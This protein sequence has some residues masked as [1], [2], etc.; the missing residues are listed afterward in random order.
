VRLIYAATSAFAVPSLLA[1]AESG[2]EISAV[3]TQPDRPA[4]RG[5]NTRP[6]PVKEAA[7]A[8]SIAVEQPASLR[9]SESQSR[10]RALAPDF[11]IVAAYGQILPQAVLD[12]PRHGCVNIHAS[13]LPRWRGA[14]P[15]QRAIMAGDRESGVCIMKMDA[16]L[17]SGPVI[18]QRRCQIAPG[19][20]AG[21]LHDRLASLGAALL[22][23]SLPGYLGGHLVPVPQ[24]ADGVTY[25]QKLRKD[26]AWLDWNRPAR[27]LEYSVLGLNPWPVAQTT[28][29]GKPLRI[30][31][32]HSLPAIRSAKPGTVLS[33]GPDGIEVRCG[34]GSLRITQLQMPGKRPV[35]VRDF[36]N[37]HRLLGEVL[38]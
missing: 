1:L 29:A 14:A 10:L 8:N 6:S 18:A 19:T 5:R 25:A 22:L 15:I 17:D 34:E 33:E 9:T 37:A 23:E 12:I 4:G 20:T 38:A 36:L 28:Y 27:D 35:E 3:Y 31:R 32:A 13:L 7:A 2:Y 21:E 24:A 26:E 30:W 16:G 11:I